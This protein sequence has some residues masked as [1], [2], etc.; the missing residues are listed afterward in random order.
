MEG[1]DYRFLSSAAFQEL[2]DVGAFLEWAE[3]FGHRYGTLSEP[4]T[5]QIEQGR[6]VIL[7][8][9]VQGA[10]RVR[11]SLPDAVLI[12]LA[13]PSDQE[14]E[15]RLRARRTESEPEL[16]RRLVAAREEMNQRWWFDYVVVNDQVERAAAE[17]AAIIDKEASAEDE[18]SV[19]DDA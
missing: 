12:F 10:A 19:Q 2:I 16:Q 11:E 15:R 3:V 5:R 9:D 13:P 4:I 18:A 7:E 1:R 14:L 8:I 6:N 17:V